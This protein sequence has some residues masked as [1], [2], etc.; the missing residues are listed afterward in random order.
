MA[1]RGTVEFDDRV[2][3]LRR[4][5]TQWGH[6]G[7]HSGDGSPGCPRQYHHHH[8]VR[9]DWPTRAECEEAGVP[10]RLFWESRAGGS[11]RTA[12]A[13]LHWTAGSIR[14]TRLDANGTP[15]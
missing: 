2:E 5:E 14:L 3:F 6:D 1:R 10:F 13:T 11:G 15:W 8:D 4:G 12:Q 9:C 7:R